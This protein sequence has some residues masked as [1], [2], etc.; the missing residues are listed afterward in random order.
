V[1]TTA[2][3][4]ILCCGS[5]D[6]TD[7]EA[8]GATLARLTSTAYERRPVTV[9]VG[10]RPGADDLVRSVVAERLP[11]VTL[12]DTPERMDV[13]SL[14]YLLAFHADFAGSGTTRQLASRAVAA[15]VTAYVHDGKEMVP[16]GRVL[17]V[18]RY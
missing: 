8:I 13:A 5:R 3:C 16:A 10:T 2:R 1:S 11:G 12:A 18:G 9:Y 17:N 7:A 14:D 4:T 6:W 15:R